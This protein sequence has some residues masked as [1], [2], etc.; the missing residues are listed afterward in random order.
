MELTSSSVARTLFPDAAFAERHPDGHA[1]TED[2]NYAEISWSSSSLNPKNR[3]D[4]LSPPQEPK[5]RIDGCANL[6][7]QFYALPVFLDLNNPIRIDVF[8]PESRNIAPGFRDL[9]SVHTA[10][11][12]RDARVASLAVSH[13]IVR[14]LDHW[15]NQ[16]EDFKFFY[17]EL[18]FGSRI[19]LENITANIKDVRLQVAKTH[20]LERQLLS[21][22]SLQKMWGFPS[23]WPDLVDI[24][25]VHLLRQLHDSVSVVR[26]RNQKYIFKALTSHPKYLYHELKVLLTGSSHPNIIS[27]P[28]HLILK[29]CKFGGKIAVIGFTIHYHEKGTLR[30]CLSFRRVHNSLTLHDQFKWAIQ[31]TEALRCIRDAENFYCDL[32]LDNIVLDEHDDA[33]L[34]DFEARGVAFSA[35][36][37]EINYLEYIHSVAKDADAESFASETTEKYRQ[38]YGR[39][40]HGRSIPMSGESYKNP[41]HGY[42]V[43]WQCLDEKEREAAEVYM[44][45]RVFWCIFEGVGSPEKTAMVQHLDENELEFPQWD[46]TPEQIRDLIGRCTQ[47]KEKQYYKKLPV[48]RSGKL[49]VI[50]GAE[51]IRDPTEV[52]KVARLWWQ[53]ELKSA[54]HFLEHRLRRGAVADAVPFGRP[55]LDDLLLQLRSMREQSLENRYHG[56]N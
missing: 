25:E 13:Y 34:I 14:V 41:R 2:S 43:P 27:R 21:C 48:I 18:P 32:R 54:E 7:T 8:I 51:H 39:M 46:R 38:L 30:D 37:P 42:S 50:R 52:Q 28:E 20:F 12:L 10:I 55:G 33:V 29:Q 4:S 36:A 9:L 22:E 16:F 53:N 19:I 26:L 24:S 40:I 23:P 5:W 35:S 6:G 47:F 11:Y 49:L 56:G 31:I 3:I 1:D 15:T 45:G 17:N 44:L